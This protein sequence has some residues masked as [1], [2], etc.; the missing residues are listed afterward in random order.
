MALSARKQLIYW[1]IGSLLL[2]AIIWR[3]GDILLPFVIGGALAYLLDPLADRFESWGC[4]RFWS[5]A[6]ISILSL[7][8]LLIMV[9]AVIP[10]MAN[11]LLQF[12]EFLPTLSKALQDWIIALA[13][14][15]TPNLLTGELKLNTALQEFSGNVGAVGTAVV[16]SVLSIGVGAIN[17]LLFVLIVPVVMIYMLADW[18]IATKKINSWLPRDHAEDI[19]RLVQEI[20]RSLAGFVRGQLMVC[21]LVGIFYAI[22]L[23][24]VGLNFGFIIGIL[25]GLTSFIPFFGAIGG[26][27]LAIGMAIFQ[28]WNEPIWIG[29]VAL[30]FG[31]GQ[32]LEGNILTPRL[33]GKSIGLH[34]VWLLLALSAFGTLFGFVGMLLAVP[35]AAITGVVARYALQRYLSSPLYKGH[36]HDDNC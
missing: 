17:I 6:I 36:G 10:Y 2:L 21:A 18:D 35:L 29:V 20:D 28:F 9:I 24:L 23:E 19:R 12:I 4:T 11:Q 26:G 25:A 22:A 31:A 16:G 15:Y 13:A 1:T 14:K 27:V 8:I 30:I 32:I 5:T 33:V 3:L 34:P 7:S